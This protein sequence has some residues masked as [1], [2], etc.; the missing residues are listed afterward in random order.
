[1]PH[2]REEYVKVIC[3]VVIGA[4]TADTKCIIKRASELLQELDQEL[5]QALLEEKAKAPSSVWSSLK[6]YIN[7][8]FKSGNSIRDQ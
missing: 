1:M 2:S 5:D 7:K 4:P 6:N 3:A 8:I